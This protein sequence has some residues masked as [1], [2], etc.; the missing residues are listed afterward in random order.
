MDKKEL[1][2]LYCSLNVV[3]RFKLRIV[4]LAGSWGRGDAYKI[5][6]GNPDRSRELWRPG[7]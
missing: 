2:N 4:K 1:N 3:S 7:A 6:V 5:L